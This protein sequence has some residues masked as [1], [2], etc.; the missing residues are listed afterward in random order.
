[1]RFFPLVLQSCDN[2]IRPKPKL[3]VRDLPR[4]RDQPAGPGTYLSLSPQQTLRR[5]H[6]QGQIYRLAD[7]AIVELPDG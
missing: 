2:G 6:R 4:R 5:F 3:L 1:M 7:G